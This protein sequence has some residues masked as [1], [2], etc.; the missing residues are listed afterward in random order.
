M[1]KP[2]NDYLKIGKIT[3][4]H[5]LKGALKIVSFAESPAIFKKD[6]P[7]NI[8]K[9]ADQTTTCLIN[10]VTPYKNGV[11]LFLH[12]ID[13]CDKAQKLVGHNLF[14]AKQV[15]PHTQDDSYYWFDLI[16]LK[17]FTVNNRYLG[18]LED[19][20]ITGSN[21]VYVVHNLVEKKKQEILIPAMVSVVIEINLPDKIMRV[22]LPEGL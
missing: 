2:D 10:K 16:G 4:T 9:R 18:T 3:G 11:R 17:V 21:D 20:I 14:I 15:L 1:Q 7:I 5:G 13:D 6:L 19:I 22:D 8:G 12:G